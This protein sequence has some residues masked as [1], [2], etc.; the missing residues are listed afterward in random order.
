MINDYQNYDYLEIIVK[1]DN[2]DEIVRWY[3]RLL[4]SEYQRKDDKIYNDII[5]VFF[6][7]PHKIPNKD[8]LQLLQVYYEKILNEKAYKLKDKHAKSEALIITTVVLAIILV[9]G[10]FALAF[11]VKNLFAY[12]GAGLLFA[13]SCVG[14]GISFSFIKTLR[15]KENLIFEAKSSEYSTQIDKIMD[16]ISILTGDKIDEKKES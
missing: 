5:H 8:R 12:L 10:S 16:E 14:V 6:S 3:G 15:K 7:R 4:W 1:K 9:L 13:L 11:L 2:A